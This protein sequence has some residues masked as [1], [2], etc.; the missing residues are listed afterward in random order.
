LITAGAI[1]GLP[2]PALAA[3]PWQNPQLTAVIATQIGY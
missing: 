3:T 2:A 1:G